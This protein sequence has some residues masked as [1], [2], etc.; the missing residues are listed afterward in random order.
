MTAKSLELMTSPGKVFHCLIVAGEMSVYP[1]ICR[2]CGGLLGHL[3]IFNFV[4]IL[5]S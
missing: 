1:S 4:S 3:K 2:L 5:C